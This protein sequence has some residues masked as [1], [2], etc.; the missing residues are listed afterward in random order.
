MD[1][2]LA[3][4]IKGA[5]FTFLGMF[6]FI[7]FEFISRVIIARFVT[8]SEYGAFNIGLSLLYI[9]VFISCLG[10]QGGATRCIAYFRG[11]GEHEKVNGIVYSSLQMSIMTSIFLF[12][13]AFYLSDH[14][15]GIFHIEQPDVIRLFIISFPFLVLIEM[16]SSIF[17]G[18][19]RVDE[20][21]Y[22]RDVLMSLLKVA[23]IIITVA[24]GFGFIG[25]IYAYSLSII[26][27]A[28]LFA[29]YAAK[30]LPIRKSNGFESIRNKL[31]WFSTPLLFTFLSTLIIMRTDTLMLGYF[32]TSDIVGLYNSASPIA[33]LIPIFLNSITFIYVPISS[34]LYSNNRIA[35]LKQ[36]YAILT[37]WTLLLTL[38]FFFIIFIFP[39]AVLNIIFGPS[40]ILA[41]DALRI[42]ALGA[43]INVIT[44]QNAATLVVLGKTK[45]NMI[46]DSIGAI[47]N[48]LL[49]LILIP[50][51]G[52]IGAAIASVISIGAINILKSVQIFWSHRIHPF[53][54]NFLKLIVTSTILIAIFYEFTKVLSLTLISIWIL[55]FFL[56]LF[57]AIYMICIIITKSF[58]REDIFM[59]KELGNLIRKKANF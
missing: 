59:Y 49:N 12:M 19:G 6:S 3:K 10:L 4:I 39:E 21:I 17:I 56:F 34:Y 15:S 25:I 20:R 38:P 9:L 32:K 37:K 26:I 46:D 16:L 13:I 7:F 35:E 18:Y 57:L 36:N 44:G 5:A 11:R 1:E 43:L 48:V 29:F 58:D 33:Q 55:I 47:L 31:F 23:G 42:L 41:S 8:S 24:L 22:F 52:I 51:M 2:S 53:N 54:V 45:L 30:K 14:L 40:Y 50:A 28:L 27:S